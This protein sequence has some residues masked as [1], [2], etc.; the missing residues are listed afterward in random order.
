[1]QTCGR[2]GWKTGGPAPFSSTL[3]CYAWLSN[4]LEKGL[5]R[6][7]YVPLAK[8]DGYLSPVFLIRNSTSRKLGTGSLFPSLRN[9]IRDDQLTW[10]IGAS[11]Q[12]P[13]PASAGLTQIGF[14]LNNA[15]TNLLQTRRQRTMYHWHQVKMTGQKEVIYG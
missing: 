3:P 13:L 2:V 4:T 9:H 15:P 12:F 8:A 6:S 14:R 1:M 11:P 5:R 7:G 10:E